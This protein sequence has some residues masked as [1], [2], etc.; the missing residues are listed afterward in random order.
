LRVR[1]IYIYIF[2]PGEEKAALNIILVELILHLILHSNFNSMRVFN[3]EDLQ[4]AFG[5]INLI[6]GYHRFRN[7]EN[8]KSGSQC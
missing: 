6:I 5:I 4:Y 2:T 3:F 1:Y 7:P 8:Q